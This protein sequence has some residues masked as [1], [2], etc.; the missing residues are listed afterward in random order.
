MDYILLT[1]SHYD[2]VLGVPSVLTAYPDAKVVAGAYAAQVFART[3]AKN[4][5]RE[6]NRKA[7]EM[8]EMPP[9]DSRV[10]QL[11][12]DIPIRDGD[13]V[14]CGELRF[15]AI[16][17]PGHTKCS[18]GY[19]LEE[20]KLFLGTETLGVFF[21]DDTYLPSFLVGYQTAL[22]SFHKIRMLDVKTMLLPHYG[23][24]DGEKLRSYLKRSEAVTRDS[25][26]RIVSML[27]RGLTEQEIL[28]YFEKKAYRDQVKPTYPIDAFLMNTRIMIE[29]VKKELLQE[30]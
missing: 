20:N 24:V 30:E 13:Q 18:V 22:D 26:H 25:A 17:L 27:Q 11:R 2:H 21:G 4:I 29:R 28:A 9:D 10:D 3:S 15:T 19:Y 23:V 6:L 12:V 7:A 14:V 1:H 5:M 16:E 8:H